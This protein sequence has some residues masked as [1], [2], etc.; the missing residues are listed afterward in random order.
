MIWNL[1]LWLCALHAFHEVDAK[2]SRSTFSCKVARGCPTLT[3]EWG[4]V[5]AT[6]P[7]TQLSSRF[8]DVKVWPGGARDWDWRETGTHHSPGTQFQDVQELLSPPQT[9]SKSLELFLQV[10]EVV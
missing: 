5:I 10:N 6:D 8:R 1:L 3:V 9:A 7:Q 2:S 4:K